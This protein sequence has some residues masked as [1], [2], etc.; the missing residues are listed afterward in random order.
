MVKKIMK[1]RLFPDP[2]LEDLHQIFDLRNKFS[3]LSDIRSI[4]KR[5]N[6]HLNRI[7]FSNNS[8]ERYPLRNVIRLICKLA[9]VEFASSI[10]KIYLQKMR[11]GCDYFTGSIMVD[12]EISE[13]LVE[14]EWC[15]T[16]FNK[17]IGFDR[18]SHFEVRKLSN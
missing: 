4:L 3:P 1:D 14:Y 5:E 18:F 9:Q 7:I 15:W 2:L 12:T 13:F 16:D 17:G 6:H 11:L 8:S 10:E